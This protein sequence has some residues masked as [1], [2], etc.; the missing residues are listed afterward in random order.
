MKKHI[1]NDSRLF[2]NREL[3][4][5]EFNTRV[6]EEAQDKFNPLFER[7][8][9]LSIVSSN[10]DEFFMV[11]VGSLKDQIN[12]GFD[13]PDASGITAREQV[14]MI[15]EK[16]A[17][18]IR[19]QYN[20]LSYSLLPFLK[21]E[22]VS[23]K[24]GNKLSQN[25]LNTINE[26]FENEV[27]PVL[28]TM[29]VDE[30]R[31]FPLIANRTL[32]LAVLL[33]NK[34]KSGCFFATVQVPYVLPRFIEVPDS[35][36]ELSYILME[37][38]IR[39]NISKLFSGY[40]ILAVNAFRITRNADLTLN[41]D[42]ADD[43]LLEIEK[44]LK[45][46]KWGAAVRLEVEANCD[47]RIIAILKEALELSQQS[48]FRIKG[49]IDLTFLSKITS[50]HG[51]A[52][53]KNPVYPS[54]YP[55]VFKEYSDFFS[56]IKAKDI[57]VHHPYE[58]FQSV[59]DFVNMAADDPDVL[60]IKMTLYR[61]SSDSPIIRALLRAVENGKQ[62]TV[63]FEIKARF[64]EENN[65]QWAKKLEEAGC[66]V[67]YG[68]IGLKTHCKAILII[69]KESDGI[70]RYVH[71]STGN[72]NEIT[73]KLYTDIGLFTSNRHIGADASALF[74]KLTGYSDQPDFY[75]FN[76]AP[77]G[78]R[79]KISELIKNEIDV[80]ERNKQS[81]RIMIKINSLVDSEIIKLLY[82]ASASGV[83]VDLIVRG[84]CCLRP[85]IKG[86]SENIRVISIVDRYLE[87]SRIFY[88]NNGGRK[89]IFLSSA[90]LMERN[91]DRRVELMFPVYD[92]DLKER[93]K[94][95]LESCL[96]DNVKAR[97]L[98]KNG[99][100]SRVNRRNKKP[101]HAQAYFYKNI[102]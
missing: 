20:C 80:S 42:E 69:R 71:M 49:P 16:V 32:N 26:Y 63:L 34:D 64:D 9:F 45:M 90:D 98:D 35:A 40:N 65:I 29:A 51:R 17:P 36:Q 94:T 99:N 77:F 50:L 57:L 39:M 87:H 53:L 68:L 86:I 89:D 76:A 82:K 27:Y 66:H 21:K 92:E 19:D 48:I 22:G 102:L 2:I 93:L 85:G 70:K 38:I 52:N 14:Q 78:L 43:L 30:S 6:L 62:V 1:N 7:I 84:I 79:R 47:E 23:F 4:W 58:D 41:E 12:A 96:K 37:E 56:A 67:T 11:R 81:G 28:T 31:P 91:L 10:L 72:Y 75:A 95:I 83:R 24:S 5:L 100:Y 54:V 15:Y 33:K 55:P 3:S 61:I 25:Q 88:F 59:I 101:V 74:N 97:E 44:S 46:R 8:K 13:K 18:M 60:A 73:A